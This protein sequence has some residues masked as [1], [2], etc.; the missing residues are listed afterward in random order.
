MFHPGIGTK[1]KSVHVRNREGAKVHSAD[2]II[3]MADKIATLADRIET[4]IKSDREK[5][6]VKK[7]NSAGDNTC[8]IYT[9]QYA[10]DGFV[11]T[12]FS[13]FHLYPQKRTVAMLQ[14][15]I[16]CVMYNNTVDAAKVL[17]NCA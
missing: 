2:K 9:I 17:I 15:H 5:T 13:S 4:A 11:S 8:F 6:K 14:M 16:N 10:Q 7:I 3:A 12:T 1:I